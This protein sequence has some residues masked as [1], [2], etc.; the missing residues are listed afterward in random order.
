MQLIKGGSARM[1]GLARRMQLPVWQRG[2]SDHRIRDA[3]DYG[4]HIRYVEQNP[5]RKLLV[6][7]ARDYRWSSVSGQYEMDKAPQG[8]KPRE[9]QDNFGTAEAVP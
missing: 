9:R 2:F 3:A 7:E 5:V 1:L 8:L 4:N 6:A